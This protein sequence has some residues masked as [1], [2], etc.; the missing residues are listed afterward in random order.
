MFQTLHRRLSFGSAI[1]FS[2]F[3]FSSVL[4]ECRYHKYRHREDCFCCL[5]LLFHC[6]SSSCL[7]TLWQGLL[8]ILYS[9]LFFPTIFLCR[10]SLAI[11][12]AGEAS[13]LNF[14]ITVFH[15]G[16]RKRLDHKAHIPCK[17]SH[18]LKSFQIF[19]DIIR[20]KSMYLIPIS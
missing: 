18:G 10:R 20:G 16:I 17:V 12:E 5:D 15:L 11:R 9:L 3:K 14:R 7:F 19:F 2:L 4:V 1:L 13:S 8:T 6:F